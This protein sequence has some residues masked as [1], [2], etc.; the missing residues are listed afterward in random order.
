MICD[1]QTEVSA[2]L[3]DP[4]TFNAPVEEID[5][6]ISRIFLAGTR[7]YKL[8]RAVKLPYA[9]FSTP[10][11]RLA[12][13]E[14]ELVLNGPHAPGLYLAVRRITRTASGLEF[15][16][17]GGLVDAVVEM[18][19]FD[20]DS[21]FDD[22][23]THGKLTPDLMTAVAREIARFH[24]AAP[25]VQDGTG[26]DNL[27]G[28]LDINRAGFHTSS[29]FS[30]TQ[31]DTLDT[32]F[33]TALDRHEMLLNQRASQG[34]IRRC[35]GDLHLRNICLFN[36]QPTLFDCIEFNDQ[37]A[38]IDVLY[39]L[40]FL[41]MDLWHRDLHD[42]ANLTANR[43]FD[44][45]GT[46]DGFVLLPFLMALRAAV[47]SHVTATLS[48]DTNS[49]D[50]IAEA[51]AYYD[52]ALSLLTRQHPTSVVIG[53]LSGTGKTT[54]SE[55]LAPRIA[56]PPG[57]RIVE[58]DRTRKALFN[59]SSETRLPDTAYAPHVSDQVYQRMADR[60]VA[61]LTSGAPVIVDAVFDKADRR[62]AIDQTL[63]QAGHQ[64]YGILLQASPDTL[65]KRVK[66][67]VGG[68]SDATVEVLERQLHRDAG[69]ISW[70]VIRS[71]RPVQDVVTDILAHLRPA[72]N[73]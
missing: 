51:R 43:Y 27:A 62:A 3:T 57:A 14:K 54:I 1:D 18:Q 56:P 31:I 20:Q 2:F 10:E 35:H 30:E 45:I 29:V 53:G 73:A 58:S 50:Q 59:V 32:A 47:R 8:K 40:A 60:A 70:T 6:H 69:P 33:R 12:A 42:L 22:L 67:R 48:E 19:R 24:T 52:L 49:Q 46:D 61:I 68:P 65:R 39:D 13:C 37:I 9:D 11:I 44:A 16:G 72:P 17:A 66:A 64:V 7:V 41:L 5:T 38:T 23:A 4:T 26:A 21:L 25:V 36:G 55:A 28:V 34:T 63:Q 15:D 71:D